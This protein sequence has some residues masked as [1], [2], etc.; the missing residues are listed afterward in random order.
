MI[1]RQL[2]LAAAI[3][4]AA[5]FV[6]AAPAVAAPIVTLESPAEAT[7]QK[8]PAFTGS[9]AT[10][11]AVSPVTIDLFQGPAVKATPDL[12]LMVPIG[13]NGR[14]E[15]PPDVDLAEGT[16]TARASQGD[17]TGVGTSEPLTFAVDTVPPVTPTITSP[18]LGA[19]LPTPTP[20]ITGRAGTAAGDNAAVALI[21][22]G[23]TGDFLLT[24]AVGADGTF[25]LATPPLADGPYG[26][27]ASQQDLAGNGVTSVESGFTIDTK[28]PDTTIDDGP[29]PAPGGDRNVQVTFGGTELATF[30][31][32]LDGTAL[33]ACEPPVLVLRGLKPGKHALTV[34]AV[35][36]AGN[37]D[38]T[39]ARAEFKIAPPKIAVPPGVL[40]APRGGESRISLRCPSTQAAGP[41]VGQVVLRRGA[42]S[43]SLKPATFRIRPGKTARIRLILNFTGQRLLFQHGRIAVQVRIVAADGRG[44]VGRKT[45]RRTLVLP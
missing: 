20:T 13:A 17:A 22:H 3:A 37:V 14:Y 32:E 28:P 19:A 34:A 6:A 27:T 2:A 45:I 33:A 1:R 23:P 36:P 4:A 7:N 31:C 16:W 41:C 8:R 10:G 24:A 21:V 30:R 43:L 42:R 38:P 40:V 12:S 25:S 44:N 26:V 35:D 39:P 11:P 9:G 29:I 15:A 5:S 18:V